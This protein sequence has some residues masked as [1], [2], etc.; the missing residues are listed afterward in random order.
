MPTQPAQVN[1]TAY[2]GFVWSETYT[3]TQTPGGP[4][5]DLTGLVFELVIRPTVQDKTSP[6]LVQV[7][8]SASNAQGSIT[9][10]P[11]TG[12]V[13]VDLTPAATL[14]LGQGAR[15]Y[16]LLSNPNTGTDAAWVEGI[17]TSK[18]IATG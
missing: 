11:L 12:V 5:I 16:T 18:L 9:V 17:F 10:T 8:S 2:A 1:A 4:P 15:P 6:A 3:L 13:A 14:L 7:S